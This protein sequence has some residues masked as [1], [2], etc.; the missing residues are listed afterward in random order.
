MTSETGNHGNELLAFK[1]CF[2]EY[3][4]DLKKRLEILNNLGNVSSSH[5]KTAILKALKTKAL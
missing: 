5:E 4:N 3:L 1:Q 2:M